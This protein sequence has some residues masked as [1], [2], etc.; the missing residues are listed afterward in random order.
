[1]TS[2]NESTKLSHLPEDP[3]LRHLRLTLTRHSPTEG[4]PGYLV[5]A[6]DITQLKLR[7]EEL[8][9]LN[10]VA[11][12]LNSTHDLQ[13]VLELAIERIGTALHAEAASLL[14]RDDATGELVFAVAVGPV[15]DRLRG[16]R[17]APGQ[18]IAGWVTRPRK[19]LL[20]PDVS[21]DPRF[22]AESTRPVD[23]SPVQSCAFP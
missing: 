20:V 14:L 17:L 12:I 9:A 10:H 23:S 11:S 22:S 3:I 13:R 8:D 15:A 4:F 6:Q 1:M 16:R 21:S 5:V 18:G 7:I 19:P 2:P